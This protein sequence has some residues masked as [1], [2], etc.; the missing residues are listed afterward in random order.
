MKAKIIAKTE[1]HPD[2]T[3]HYTFD[4]IDDNDEVVI[5]NQSVQSKPSEAVTTIQGRVAEV[6]AQ[7]EAENDVE[8]DEV[9]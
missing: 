8:V 6:A 7:Y 3:R 4:I 2:L 5:A 1:L 9:I